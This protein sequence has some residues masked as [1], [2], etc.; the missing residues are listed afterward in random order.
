MV[1]DILQLAQVMAG[2]DRGH[3]ALGHI[4]SEEAF[5]RLPDHRIQTVERFVTEEIIGARAHTQDHRNL[6]FHAL[7]KRADFPLFV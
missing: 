6:L 1:A 3:A 4:L 2:D 7:G 5:D